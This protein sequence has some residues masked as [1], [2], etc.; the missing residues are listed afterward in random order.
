MTY[1]RAV[2]A[3]KEDPAPIRRIRHHMVKALAGI[4][5]RIRSFNEVNDPKIPPRTTAN[6]CARKIAIPEDW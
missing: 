2:H 1:R 6:T 4:K 5:Q 3:A